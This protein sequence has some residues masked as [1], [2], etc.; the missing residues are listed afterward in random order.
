MKKR[1]NQTAFIAGSPF[2]Q[3][4]QKQNISRGIPKDVCKKRLRK[5]QNAVGTVENFFAVIFS[6]KL[7][8]LPLAVFVFFLYLKFAAIGSFNLLSFVSHARECTY[9]FYLCDYSVGFCSRL[10]IG[11]LFSVLYDS[12]NLTL[13]TRWANASLLICIILQ[14]LLTAL[15]MRLALAKTDRLMFL[16]SFLFILNPLTTLENAPMNGS[17]DPYIMILFLVWLFFA[18]TNTATLIAPFVSLICMTIH[19]EFLFTF[20]PPVLALLLYK[21][22]CAQ[23]KKNRLINGIGFFSTA[24]SSGGL[25][26]YFVFFAKNFLKLTSDEFYNVMAAKLNITEN[27]AAKLQ[28]LY[29]G[30]LL[31]RYYFDFYIFGEYEGPANFGDPKNFLSFLSNYRKAHAFTGACKTFLPFVLPPL[32]LFAG[33]WICCMLKEKG[34]RKLP[35]LSFIGIM[36]VLIPTLIISTDAWRFTAAVLISQFAILFTLYRDSNSVLHDVLHSRVLRNRIAAV[37]FFLLCLPY[38][39]WAFAIEPFMLTF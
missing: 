28:N 7:T 34:I 21:F 27:A 14:S 8:I 38:E 10:L 12:V 35:Y 31:Y 15:V 36:I 5:A 17:L 1:H 29:N 32:I 3:T 9:Q 25:F 20:L 6:Y 30:N 33:L 2:E 16:I 19:Y 24:L 22:C 13:I 18:N 4:A 26:I 23:N 39:Y 37:V 11:A